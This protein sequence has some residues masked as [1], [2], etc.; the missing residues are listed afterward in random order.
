MAASTR[1]K[2]RKKKQRG[3]GG[4]LYA[5]KIRRRRYHVIFIPRISKNGKGEGASVDENVCVCVA[6]YK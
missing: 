4:A 3:T 2:E 5:A 6:K 1:E